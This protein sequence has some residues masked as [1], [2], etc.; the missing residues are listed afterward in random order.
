[1]LGQYVGGAMDNREKMA[2]VKDM[3]LS[4]KTCVGPKTAKWFGPTMA[5]KT[6]WYNDMYRDMM[7]DTNAKDDG[8]KGMFNNLYQP[9]EGDYTYDPYSMTDKPEKPQCKI[10][11]QIYYKPGLHPFEDAMRMLKS[12]GPGAGAT[13]VLDD[14]TATVCEDRSYRALK[15][16]NKVL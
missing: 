6:R 4:N 2:M 3:M 5:R 13:D 9:G 15:N 10:P 16:V 7:N 8:V 1:M 14:E 12:I 11:G